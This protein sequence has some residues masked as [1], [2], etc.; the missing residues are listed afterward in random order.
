M[1]TTYI[2]LLLRIPVN[3]P[4]CGKQKLEIVPE[5]FNLLY[6]LSSVKI[7]PLSSFLTRNLTAS[8]MFSKL[9]DPS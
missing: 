9:G 3:T 7:I 5:L 2:L 4:P 1:I 6:K 8:V